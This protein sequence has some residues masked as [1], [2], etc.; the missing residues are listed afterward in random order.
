M[1]LVDGTLHAFA[2]T[3]AGHRRKE[4]RA[5]GFVFLA[6]LSVGLAGCSVNTYKPAVDR[7]AAATQQAQEAYS[8]MEATVLSSHAEGLRQQLL[9]GERRA[10]IRA[11]SCKE[12]SENCEILIVDRNG[13]M[14]PLHEKFENIN[15][16]MGGISDYAA[17]LRAIVASEAPQQVSASFSAAAGSIKNLD[18]TIVKIKASA[19]GANPALIDASANIA[20]WLAGEYVNLLQV[21]ALR[22]ATASADP[23]IQKA[24]PILQE[25]ATAAAATINAD[26]AQ[27]VDAQRE[28]Y[29]RTP[30][31]RAALDRFEKAVREFDTALKAT[32]PSVFGAMGVAHR[33]LTEALAG[34]NVTLADAYAAIEQ[35]AKKAENLH[36]LF[37]ALEAA[38][39]APEKK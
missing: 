27:R 29:R 19:A 34:K 31:D 37:A 3:A 25:S 10:T 22:K 20:G 18:S 5:R 39:K 6:I 28:A 21:D 14:V 9:R 23:V 36:K 2:H 30:G 11:G 8:K 12:Q 24:L 33:D 1:P 4:D 35:F 7:F 32:S 38:A 16:L 15:L 26:F 17:N 13:K